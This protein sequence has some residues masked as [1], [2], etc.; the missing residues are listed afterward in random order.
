MKKLQE[1]ATIQSG[2]FAKSAVTPNALYLQLSDFNEEGKLR[3]ETACTVSIV[4]KAER[5]LLSSGDLL[6]AS[7][8]NNNMCIVV[9]PIQE[10]SVASPTFL[11]IRIHDK[12]QVLPE[13]VAWF[14]N[15]PSTRQQ[16]AGKVAKGS[17][18]QSIS[19]SDLTD[20]QVALPSIEKQQICIKLAKLQCREQ[21]LYRTIAELRKKILEYKITKG[22]K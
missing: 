10:R 13:Y 22:I 12:Q 15:L 7:K 14:L 8:G 1:I 4:G 17:A 3:P 16:L 18:I 2:V 11:V 9:P 6:L 20:L 19:I 21:K 5:H